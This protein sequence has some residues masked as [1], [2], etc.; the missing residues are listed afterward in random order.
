MRPAAFAELGIALV[1]KGRGK[2]ETAR[3]KDTGAVVLRVDPKFYRPLE[4]T[5][6]VGDARL[7]KKELGW[8][9]KTIGTAVARRMARADF[10]ALTA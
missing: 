3:R 5:T 8:K 9:P 10:E 7:A 4:S 1:F 2:A 6:L